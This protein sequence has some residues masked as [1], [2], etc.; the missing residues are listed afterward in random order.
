[1]QV[2]V[3]ERVSWV[4]DGRE[5]DAWWVRTDGIFLCGRKSQVTLGEALRVG[6]V[7]RDQVLLDWSWCHCVLISCYGL[8]Y[9]ENRIIVK[10]KLCCCKY[11]KGQ[12]VVYIAK[13]L[14]ISP[15]NAVEHC[16]RSCFE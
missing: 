2:T 8:G 9:L 10:V 4:H 7:L 3:K 12:S 6:L 5:R 14:P 13:L 1:M 11:L 16:L 15:A